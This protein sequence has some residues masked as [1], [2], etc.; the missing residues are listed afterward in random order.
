MST[1]QEIED[2]I[3]TLPQKEREQLADDLPSILPELNG[4]REW[5]RI[6]DDPQPSKALTA[7]GD[8]LD[9]QWARNSEVFPI[10]TD[11][12]FEDKP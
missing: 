3:R 7:F 1:L 9:A 6:I 5:R 10:L 2:A 4:E 12:D 11:K 8:K